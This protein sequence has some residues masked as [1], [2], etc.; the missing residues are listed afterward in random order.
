MSNLHSSQ[1]LLVIFFSP[2]SKCIDSTSRICR[3]YFLLHPSSS[4]FTNYS[5]TGAV[6]SN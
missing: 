3:V 4:L 2:L 5:V 6:G 1:S